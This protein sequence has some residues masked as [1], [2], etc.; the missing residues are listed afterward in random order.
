MD[1]PLAALDRRSR[2]E[3]LPYLETLHETLSVPILYVSHDVAEIE[4]LADHLV[5]VE[6]GRVVASGP[7]MDILT[8]TDLPIARGPDAS[9][10]VEAS[11]RGFDREFALTELEVAGQRVLVPGRVADTGK[12]RRVRIA[13]ADVSLATGRPSTTSILNVLEARIEAVA[14]VDEAQVN[15]V[16]RVGRPEASCR[17]LA[18]ISRRAHVTLAL[19]A[20]QTVFAQVKAVSLIA[21]RLGREP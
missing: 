21:D 16:L 2:E 19:H 13:A 14:P 12:P 5:L 20:G 7:L 1:E 11:V 17:L 3:I 8:E 18:R 9:V 4:R 6:A 15:V 10:V